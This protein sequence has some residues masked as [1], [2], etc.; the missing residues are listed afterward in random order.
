MKSGSGEPTPTVAPSVEPIKPKSVN[1]PDKPV[2]DNEL[3]LAV[4]SPKTGLQGVS[5]EAQARSEIKQMRKVLG[6]TEIEKQIQQI[7]NAVRAGQPD[8][9]AAYAS[10]A[11]AEP[12]N[13][14]QTIMAQ[15]LPM[16]PTILEALT[17]R[18]LGNEEAPSPQAVLW[19]EV[20]KRYDE[21]KR[22]EMKILADKIV[23]G[24]TLDVLV[25][26]GG[27]PDGVGNK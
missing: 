8:G 7:A 27:K 25:E 4:D 1:T 18:L 17:K 5:L 24:S 3:A 20:E 13:P 14:M 2:G 21:R 22:A 6:I 12:V 26:G 16:L 23:G 9:G 11:P 15:V 19:Q 10:S